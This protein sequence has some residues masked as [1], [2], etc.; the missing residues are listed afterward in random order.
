MAQR[1]RG[2]KL[3]SVAAERTN[4]SSPGIWGLQEQLQGMGS[5][6]WPTEGDTGPAQSITYA[7]SGNFTFVVPDGVKTVSVVCVGGG[8]GGIEVTSGGG[9]GLGYKNI[10]PVTPGESIPI[11]V[12]AAGLGPVAGGDSWFASS[13]IVAGLGGNTGFGGAYVGDGGGSGANGVTFPLGGGGGGAAGYDGNNAGNGAAGTSPGIGSAGSFGGGGG[14]GA[15]TTDRSFG[16]GGGGVG[17]LGQG[18]SGAGGAKVPSPAPGLSGFQGGGG[19]GGSGGVQTTLG[20]TYGG[21][22]GGCGA[23]RPGTAITQGGNGAI[24]IIWPA[25]PLNRVFPNTNTGEI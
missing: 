14:G 5:F 13:S 18:E 19:S 11:S 25:A 6:S 8:G 1:Y 23:G 24:R 4:L 22:G 10:Y 2:G 9:G 20:G 7:N 12:G 3:S 21:G 15:A 16:G 17:L